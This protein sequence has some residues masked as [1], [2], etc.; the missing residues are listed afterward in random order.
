MSLSNEER[1]RAAEDLR[2]AAERIRWAGS[3]AT[4]GP[5]YT[6]EN[7]IIGGWAVTVEP[8]ERLSDNERAFTPAIFV[9][10]QDARWI[11]KASPHISVPMAELFEEAAAWL[12]HYHDTDHELLPI[13]RFA[14]P[15][16]WAVLR[17]DPRPF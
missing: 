10:E 1:T 12:D 16:A 15:L 7:D 5:W 8:I 13:V 14:L 11:E 6:A 2:H 9:N 17:V 4:P 3:R